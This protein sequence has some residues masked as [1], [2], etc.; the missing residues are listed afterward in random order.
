MLNHDWIPWLNPI[1][2]PFS[3]GFPMV[4]LWFSYGFPMVFL[5]VSWLNHHL[6]NWVSY[7]PKPTNET[8]PR[9][10]RRHH[11]RREQ[12]GRRP[13]CFQLAML[14]QM[15][16]DQYLLIP[17]LGGWTSINPSY[18]DV[19]KRG[20]R[21]WHTAKFNCGSDFCGMPNSRKYSIA[22]LYLVYKILKSLKIPGKD[23]SGFCWLTKA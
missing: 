11:R 8:V 7:R 10:Q 13:G 9:S 22:L 3:Y 4:F 2:P 21:F 17:F 20:T 16:M 15:G 18:F 23:P 6:P 14:S 1:K 19:N 12:R 5:H